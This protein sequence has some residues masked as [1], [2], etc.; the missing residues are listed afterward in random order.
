MSFWPPLSS[1]CSACRMRD[2]KTSPDACEGKF[3]AWLTPLRVY[4]LCKIVIVLATLFGV[5]TMAWVILFHVRIPLDVFVYLVMGT[6]VFLWA[7][8]TLGFIGKPLQPDSH[9]S[10]YRDEHC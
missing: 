1:S 9:L 8:L 6:F 4:N 2:I 10:E 7:G 3:S 5:G